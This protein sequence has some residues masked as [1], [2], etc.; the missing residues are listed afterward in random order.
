V[1]GVLFTVVLLLTPLLSLF[2]NDVFYDVA[3]RLNGAYDRVG[4]RDAWRVTENFQSFIRGV[5]E[6]RYFPPDQAAHL[7]DVRS[8][9]VLG[10]FILAGA[11]VLLVLSLFFIVFSRDADLFVAAL[12]TGAS[13]T[14][15]LLGLLVLLALRWD[16]FFEGF[17]RLFF[18][19][20]WLFPSHTL[21][22]NLW[23]RNFFVVA[24]L[25]SAA[26]SLILAVF[27]LVTAS[28]VRRLEH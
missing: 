23:G 13:F 17:H 5:D 2:T 1:S 4:V 27:L 12:R 20:G 22:M 9:Y 15:L 18:S 19:G 14:F 26:Q 11:L 21:M 8:L 16:W 7:M 6:L 10:R 28:S 24:A 25:F 3:Y